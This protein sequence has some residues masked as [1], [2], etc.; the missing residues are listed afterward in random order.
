M[1]TV[2]EEEERESSPPRLLR[3]GLP[4]EAWTGRHAMSKAKGNNES[5]V[6]LPH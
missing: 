4:K 5:D 1:E 6:L 3:A 2:G